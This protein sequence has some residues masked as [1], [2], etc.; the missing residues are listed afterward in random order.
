M[1]LTIVPGRLDLAE[2]DG[3]PAWEVETGVADAAALL[4]NSTFYDVLADGAKVMTYGVEVGRR[5]GKLVAWVT[6]GVGHLP[7]FDLTAGVMPLI[8]QQL[9]G[10]D[11]LNVRT[12]RPG[13]VKK[14]EKQGYATSFIL[15]KELNQ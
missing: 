8:E 10:V 3:V 2:L 4:A 13:L 14:L 15:T 12:M 6:V 1:T 7:G 5:G 11:V 9:A